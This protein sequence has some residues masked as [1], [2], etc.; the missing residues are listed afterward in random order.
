MI[1]WSWWCRASL[2]GS[3]GSIVYVKTTGASG[4]VSG[5]T[6]AGIRPLWTTFES[7]SLLVHRSTILRHKPLCLFKKD[8][9]TKIWKMT[10]TASNPSIDNFAASRIRNILPTKTRKMTKRWNLLLVSVSWWTRSPILNGGNDG[11]RGNTKRWKIL[12]R[13]KMY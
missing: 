3:P 13:G 7:E 2:T 4:T 9:R 5:W 11:F 12:N 6:A 10:S 1:Q 8:I